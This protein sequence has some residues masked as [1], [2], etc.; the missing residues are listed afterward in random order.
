MGNAPLRCFLGANSRYGFYSLY[1]GFTRPE[2]GDF[3]WLIKG[4]PGCGKSSFMKRIG[5]AA[6]AKGQN[7]EYIHCSGDPDSLD[8]VWLP[9]LGTG[10][11][12][13]TAPH[14]MDAAY[15][16]ASSMYIDLGRFYD[17]AA[18]RPRNGEIMELNRRYKALYSTAYAQISAAAEILPR[19]IPGL[20]GGGE[21]A[22]MRK[23]LGAFAAR[24]FKGA[25]KGTGRVSHRFLDA[26]SCKGR[27]FLWDSAENLCGRLCL[28]DNELGMAH[29]YL[30]ELAE[31]AAAEGL[32]VTVCHDCLDPK[33]ISALLLPG[34]ELALVASRPGLECPCEIYRHIRLDAMADRKTLA[35]HRPLIRKNAKLSRALLDAAVETLAE[36][37]ALHDELE[38]VYNPHVDFGGVYGE[39]EKHISA[40]FDH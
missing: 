16:A 40:L 25:Q 39:A 35:A 6:E 36:A 24:E 15:P 29:F 1:E 17:T 12:D 23:K 7:V 38:A 18:L 10:Y 3:L 2:Q 8:G 21:K 14:A 37:K 32:D 9:A 19:Y 13:A 20:W 31:A 4:G 26:I 33:L 30:S 34:A 5:A 22:K 27:L 11:M 28:L